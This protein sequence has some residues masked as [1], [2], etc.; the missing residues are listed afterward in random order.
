MGDET[1]PLASPLPWSVRARAA[2]LRRG[3]PVT[4]DEPKRRRLRS[5]KC[6]SDSRGVPYALKGLATR[7]P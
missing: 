3:P 6:T 1:V 4:G 2:R 5:P 7:M